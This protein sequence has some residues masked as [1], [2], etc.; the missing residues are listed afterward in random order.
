MTQGSPVQTWS[1]LLD[2]GPDVAG[3][4]ALCTFHSLFIER[5]LYCQLLAHV[6]ICHFFLVFGTFFFIMLFSEIFL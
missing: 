4:P 5:P 3:T 6:L 1:S 2:R